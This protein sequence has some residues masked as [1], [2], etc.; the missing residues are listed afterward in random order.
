MS[1]SNN[2]TTVRRFLDLYDQHDLDGWQR[3]LAPDLTAHVSGVADLDV[4]GYRTLAAAY[5]QAFPDLRHDV[6]A[7]MADGDTVTTQLHVTGTHRG[8]FEGLPGTGRRVEFAM[9][10]VCQVRDG[11]LSEVWS[12]ADNLVLLRQL[13]VD[14]QQLH[15]MLQRWGR[16]ET[17]A[18]GYVNPRG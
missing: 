2:K 11:K 4:D 15:R 9:C 12:Y 3:L 17:A 14:A 8:D 16:I 7:Q 6:V 13:G 18:P 1:T 5:R 10:L